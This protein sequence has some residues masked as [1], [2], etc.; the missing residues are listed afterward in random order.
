MLKEKQ[1]EPQKRGPG[2]TSQCP[3]GAS[4]WGLMAALV[5]LG[6]TKGSWRHCWVCGCGSHLAPC[7]PEQ[8]SATAREDNTS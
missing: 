4:E 1:G 3:R 8:A 5:V 6:W 7:P 2:V